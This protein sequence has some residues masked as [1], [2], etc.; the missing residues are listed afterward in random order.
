[1]SRCWELTRRCW[2][3]E[4]KWDNLALEELLNSPTGLVGQ[5]LA[6]MSEEIAV[7]ARATVRI[8]HTPT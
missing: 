1:M 2:V 4:V 5:F 3:A 7:V 6:E 8:R